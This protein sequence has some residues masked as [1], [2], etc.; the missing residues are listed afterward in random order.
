MK[1][2][3]G[4]LLAGLMLFGFSACTTS[5]AV[6]QGSTAKAAAAGIAPAAA[7]STASTVS[8]YQLYTNEKLGFSFQIPDSWE[9]GNYTISI[10][11]ENRKTSGTKF[12]AVS[13]LFQNDTENP[14][15]TIWLVPKS[16]WDFVS[17]QDASE[18]P[19]YLGTKGDMVYYYTAAQNCPYSV[20]TK[21]DLFNSMVLLSDSVEITNRFQFLNA[22][23][24]E[25]AL[26]Q[27]ASQP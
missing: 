11:E 18:K 23:S 2:L 9:N 7:P 24:Q 20:G 25:A 17:E 27:S 19:G 14:L 5:S 3:I 4:L 1:K 26:F 21:A 13:F 15:L 16:N 12:P 6:A 22:S 8:E 10:T